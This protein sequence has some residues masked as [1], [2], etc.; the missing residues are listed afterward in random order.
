MTR[1]VAPYHVSPI[2]E[3]RLQTIA[4]NGGSPCNWNQE[5]QAVQSCEILGAADSTV[6]LPSLSERSPK[7]L[8]SA[9]Y[10]AP[11]PELLFIQP[12]NK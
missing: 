5:A 3:Q 8:S 1:V 2:V 6:R 7:S 4:A 10:A 9:L 12:K 11:L